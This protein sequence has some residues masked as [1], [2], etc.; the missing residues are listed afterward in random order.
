M[1]YSRFVCHY[2][3]VS[4]KSFLGTSLFLIFSDFDLFNLSPPI[5][6]F[7]YHG[8]PNDT[9]K[10]LYQKLR[11]K[12]KN[13]ALSELARDATVAGDSQKDGDVGVCVA[14]MKIV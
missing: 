10:K 5:T 8:A 14:F 6:I 12:N 1:R 7:Y 13:L 9:G 2:K 3:Q 11:S 4:C